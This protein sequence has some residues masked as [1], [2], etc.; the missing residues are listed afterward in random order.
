MIMHF[1]L[2]NP[3]GKMFYTRDYFCSKVTK[4]GYVEHPVDLLI[5]SGTL[6]AAGQRVS[7][8][9][10]VA[11]RLSPAATEKRIDSLDI[12]A[13]VFLS[14]TVSWKED[15]EF[16]S[17]IKQ[18]HPRLLLIGLGDIFLEPE[19]FIKNEWL[20]AVLSDFTSDE[21]LRYAAGNDGNF[22]TVSFRRDRKICLASGKK[23][24]AQFSLA[25]PK[26]ELFLDKGYSFP[27]AHKLPFTTVLTDYGCPF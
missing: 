9:D 20:D 3:P 15:F 24:S 4:A 10:A 26:H 25:V 14:G 19:A 23:N 16:L 13:I 17:K 22:D 6:S 2:L 5:L 7:V 18:Q 8:I 21:I 1:L 12:D 11:E 27:F